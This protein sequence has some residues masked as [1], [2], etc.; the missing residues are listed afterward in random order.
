MEKKRFLLMIASIVA[1]MLFSVGCSLDGSGDTVI[2]IAAIPGV[3][4]PAAGE[5]PVTGIT[6]TDQYTGKVSW[7]PADATFDYETEYT[8]TI[9]LTAKS[10][11]TLAGVTANFF[12]V[13]GATVT[14]DADSGVVT[15]VFQVYAIGDTGPS[16][17]G[18]VFYI[19][20]GGLHGLEVA[21]SDQRASQVWIEGGSTQTTSNGNTGTAIGTGLANSNAIIAQTGHTG[22]AAQVCR[23]YNGGGLT[24]W[25][26]PSKDELDAIWDNLVDDGAGANSGVGGFADDYY[27]SSSES[28]SADAWLQHFGN[29]YQGNPSKVDGRRVR[30]VRA[31]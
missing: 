23:S 11:Y 18:I 29:G 9:T 25:F 16:G 13:A 4:A 24:D 14:H 1:I 6:K 3:T 7:S 28:N 17:V 5:T 8:A 21:P 2:D 22:S 27:W 10:G 15:A 26:L 31:F 19:T 12:T 20:D 30:A